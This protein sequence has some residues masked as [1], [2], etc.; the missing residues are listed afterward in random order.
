MHAGGLERILRR[1]VR[2]TGGVKFSAKLSFLFYRWVGGHFQCD[3]KRQWSRA[4]TQ[5]RTGL[6]H[7]V[8]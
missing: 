5:D 1:S 7:I 8:G 4:D 2:P 3:A 6:F